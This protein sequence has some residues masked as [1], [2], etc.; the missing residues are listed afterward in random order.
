MEWKL[1]A[2]KALNSVDTEMVNLMIGELK[3]WDS[4]PEARPRALLMS[5]MGGK[6]FC[7]GGDIVTLYKAHKT[8]G[9]DKT[10]LSEFFA[11][12]YLLDYTLS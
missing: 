12:E 6:A 7:A 11:R 8:E 2:P 5:G 1:N 3:R 9:A 4:K 10:C